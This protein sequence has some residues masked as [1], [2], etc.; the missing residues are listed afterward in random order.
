[1]TQAV[2]WVFYIEEG[3]KSSSPPVRSQH[4][5]FIYKIWLDPFRK[6][7]LKKRYSHAMASTRFDLWG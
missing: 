3:N 4:Q 1:M 6:P 5:K 7:V 2:A